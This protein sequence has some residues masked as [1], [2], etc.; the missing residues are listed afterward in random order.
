M[1]EYHAP[2]ELVERPEPEPDG[3]RSVV[4]KSAA[5]A[6]ARPISTPSTG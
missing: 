2:L 6:S 1:R 4:V 3:A 5:P